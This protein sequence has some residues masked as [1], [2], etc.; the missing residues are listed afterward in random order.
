MQPL[1]EDEAADLGV[2]GR[3][4]ESDHLSRTHDGTC[5]WRAP[6]AHGEAQP[7]QHILSE[8]G[9]QVNVATG[10]MHCLRSLCA[11]ASPTNRESIADGAAGDQPRAQLERDRH[12]D[13]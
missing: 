10:P 12:R 6:E 9:A 11:P 7:V 2:R 3:P 13:G 5:E 8:V 1:A 4:D